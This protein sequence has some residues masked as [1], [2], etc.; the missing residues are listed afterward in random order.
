MR[1]RHVSFEDKRGIGKPENAHDAEGTQGNNRP[2]NDGKET[3]QTACE[4]RQSVGFVVVVLLILAVAG[5]RFVSLW[6]FLFRKEDD[7]GG[8]R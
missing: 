7:G 8:R 2:C 3:P 1:A 6:I 4:E 5:V